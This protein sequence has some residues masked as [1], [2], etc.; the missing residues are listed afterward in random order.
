MTPLFYSQLSHLYCSCVNPNAYPNFYFAAVTISPLWDN[1]RLFYSVLKGKTKTMWMVIN[2]VLHTK[3]GHTFQKL[4]MQFAGE[5]LSQGAA[6]LQSQK[7]DE[8][9]RLSSIK[10]SDTDHLKTTKQKNTAD[11][12]LTTDQAE[13]YKMTQ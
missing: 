8:H 5:W 13:K 10:D 7:L 9:L 11:A 6:G 4:P 12:Q 1:K 3:I 2:A